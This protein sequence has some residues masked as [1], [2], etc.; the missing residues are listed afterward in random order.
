MLAAGSAQDDR[1][2]FFEM[3]ISVSRPTI[4]LGAIFFFVK[5]RYRLLRSFYGNFVNASLYKYIGI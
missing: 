1:F 2:F 3:T 4:G 5:L